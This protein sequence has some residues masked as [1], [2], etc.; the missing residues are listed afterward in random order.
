MSFLV[1]GLV[2]V[3]ATEID[4]DLPDDSGDGLAGG[5]TAK[6]PK[7][8][9]H[10]L[11]RADRECKHREV[12]AGL[13]A[14]QLHQESGF[15]T[16]RKLKSKAFAKG[17]AQFVDG[18]WATW[19]RDIDGKNGADP[20]DVPDAVIAQGRLMCSLLGQAK[21]SGIKGDPRALALAG[22]NAGWGAVQKYKGI[23]PYPETQHY[24]SIILR[25]VKDFSAPDGGGDLK[26]AGHST[27]AKALRKA[28]RKI[29]TPYAYG[30]GTPNGPE[31]GFCDGNNGYANGVCAASRT[32]G[33]DCS[34]LMQYAYWPKIKLPRTAHAQYDATSDHPVARDN[35]RQGDLLFWSHGT[36]FIYHVAMYAG[37]GKVLHAPR[38][39][40]SVE[41]V[42]LKTA[43]PAR[44]YRGATRP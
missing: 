27:A 36:G 42:P 38:T 23:P 12:T 10:W 33:F 15:N 19:G 7:E 43:M 35:L 8:F 1:L 24:V 29:G 44:D 16:S 28:A 14:A 25:T 3:I 34:S 39:G 9:R 5:M 41:L 4:A 32:K 17:P 22:Y 13:L 37:D 26:V 31:R 18:T 30:G 40:K 20:Y 21:K 11:R 6:V 2:L